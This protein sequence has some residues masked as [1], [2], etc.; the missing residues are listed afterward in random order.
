MA[1]QY[2]PVDQKG[3]KPVFVKLTPSMSR[4]QQV[5]KLCRAL[6][7]SGITVHP[8]KKPDSKGVAS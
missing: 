3:S 2:N 5:L 1:Y 7:K 6:E 8:S 4:E